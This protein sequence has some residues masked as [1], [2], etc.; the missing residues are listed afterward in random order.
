MSTDLGLLAGIGLLILVGVVAVA[1]FRRRSRTAPPPTTTQ[2]LAL[3]ETQVPRLP[4]RAHL[5]AEDAKQ[6]VRTFP[7]TRTKNLIGRAVQAD[8]RIDES[9]AHWDSVSREHAHIE[10]HGDSVIVI[11]NDSLNGIKVNGRRTGR[12]LLKQGWRLEIGGVPF[13]YY[14]ASKDNP[15]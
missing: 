12:N 5:Q 4:A 9:F 3:P 14:T 6:N 7:L 2:E 8:V 13:T 1:L 11:D 15:S 10:F